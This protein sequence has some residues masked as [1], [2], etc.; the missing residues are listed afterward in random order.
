MLLSVRLFS[1]QNQPVYIAKSRVVV[2]NRKERIR[3]CEQISES[4]RA[5]AVVVVVVC[6]GA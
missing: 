4:C 2:Q 6:A 5:A 3:A 1:D